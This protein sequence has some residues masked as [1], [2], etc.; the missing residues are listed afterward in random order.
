MVVVGVAAMSWEAVTKASL[1]IGVVRGK[2]SGSETT[3]AA[4]VSVTRAIVLSSSILSGAG[5]TLSTMVPSRLKGTYGSFE[6]CTVGYFVISPCSPKGKTTLLISEGGFTS[7][8]TTNCWSASKNID[9]LI[10]SLVE[11]LTPVALFFCFY[12]Q[13]SS[14]FY[15]FFLCSS[16][17]RSC[18]ISGWL[19]RGHFYFLL[20]LALIF[21]VLI[22]I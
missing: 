19:F 1:G 15:N 13:A 17:R 5:S 11:A 20:A 21:K 6:G 12:N 2:V 7:S 14:V 18:G 4:S 3:I 9:E 22:I 8:M 10:A 16:Q